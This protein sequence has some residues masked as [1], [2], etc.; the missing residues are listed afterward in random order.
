MLVKM[1][2]LFQEHLS[3]SK[4]QQLFV[5]VVFQQMFFQE[6]NQVGAVRRHGN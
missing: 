4:F 3:Q 6:G 5:E 1:M 2:L